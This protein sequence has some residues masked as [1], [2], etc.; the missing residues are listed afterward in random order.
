MSS[1]APTPIIAIKIQNIR[2]LIRASLEQ[3]PE[4]VRNVLRP[5]LR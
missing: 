4:K 1:T 2:L 3:I 5:E